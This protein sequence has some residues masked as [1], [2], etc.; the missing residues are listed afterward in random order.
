VSLEILISEGA[1]KHNLSTIRGLVAPTDL[2]VVVKSNSYGHGSLDVAKIAENEGVR[3]L[4]VLEI[5]TA[6]QVRSVLSDPEVNILAWQFDEFDSLDLVAENA[7]HL[8]VGDFA[9]LRQ[10]ANHS[11]IKVHLK[12]DTGLNRNGVAFDDWNRFVDMAL[13]LEAKGCILVEAVWSHL[14]ETS[15]EGDDKAR[16]LFKA[17]LSYAESRFGRKLIAH[18][19][20]SAASFLRPDFRFDI[21]RNGG[22]VYGIPSFGGITPEQ[23]GLIPVMTLVSKVLHVEKNLRGDF[24]V[25][26]QAGYTHGI[27]GMSAGKVEVSI[28]GN[29][30]LVS[31]VL[32]ESMLVTGPHLAEAGDDVYIF[33]NGRH[34]EQTV[35]E[36]GDAIGTLGDEICCR[37]SPS[38][39]RTIVA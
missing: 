21:I 5:P 39:K 14:A 29:R 38:L 8:G 23:M 7:I 16:S 11:G 18:L 27:P 25:S 36:W 26:V 17:A 12:I 4:G 35:R 19:S 2:M 13:D 1:L 6:L 20:A 37:I 33:G 10:L 9:Q 30:Y 31:K 3:W 24:E 15:D 22:H 32:A 34:G 28:N